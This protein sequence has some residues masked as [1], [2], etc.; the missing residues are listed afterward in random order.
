MFPGPGEFPIARRGEARYTYRMTI[1][2]E[3][4]GV[5]TPQGVAN[6]LVTTAAGIL[7]NEQLQQ[8]LTAGPQSGKLN[9]ASGKCVGEW[10]LS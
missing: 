5:S 7:K 8:P 6:A 2:V 10:R 4:N 1:T 3:V 9:D